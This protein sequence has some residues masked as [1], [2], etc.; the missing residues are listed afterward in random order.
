MTQ[1]QVVGSPS[2]HQHM[3][4]GGD[5]KSKSLASSQRL[6]RTFGPKYSTASQS[7]AQNSITYCLKLLIDM[8][9]EQTETFKRRLDAFLQTIH[10]QPQLPG[11][12]ARCS[13]ISNS[14][15][16]MIPYH[17]NQTNT[18]RETTL[19]ERDEGGSPI[20]PWCPTS[21]EITKY[22]KV[23]IY[24]LKTWQSYKLLQ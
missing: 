8:V 5:M 7:K 15:T 6:F 23:S 9:N 24:K 12:K 21:K 19:P 4:T 3:E 13:T 10:D 1:I 20:T 17:R 2:S 22:H 14:L 18:T 16:E 11:Y